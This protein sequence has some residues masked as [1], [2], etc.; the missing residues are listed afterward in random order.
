MLTIDLQEGF[1]SDHVVIELNNKVVFDER[2]V[3][4]RFEIG[5]ATRKEIKV[6]K[7]P[8]ELRVSIPEAHI[9]KKIMIDP[10]ETTHVGV[11]RTDQGIEVT[12]SSQPFGYL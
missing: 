6:P 2:N 9:I 7:R 12:R 5:F 4:S 3:R 10:A 8:Y 11:N 1:T